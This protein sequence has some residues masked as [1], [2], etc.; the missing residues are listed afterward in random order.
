MQYETHNMMKNHICS[1]IMPSCGGFRVKYD[2][3]LS[4]LVAI[5]FY[6]SGYTIAYSE[7]PKRSVV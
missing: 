2:M 4:I 5:S 1:K 3:G 7:Q 6:I